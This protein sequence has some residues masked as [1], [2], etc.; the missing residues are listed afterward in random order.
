MQSELNYTENLT[1]DYNKE[2]EALQKQIDILES[3]QKLETNRAW[4][5]VKSTIKEN[6]MNEATTFIQRATTEFETIKA[7]TQLSTIKVV[8]ELLDFNEN[9]LEAYKKRLEETHKAYYERLEA[10]QAKATTVDIE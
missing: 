7:A 6:L 5:S 4:K 1:H 3:L 10:M 9:M 2:V 8:F